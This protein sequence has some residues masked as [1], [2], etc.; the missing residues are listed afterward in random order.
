MKDNTINDKISRLFF[1][2]RNMAVKNDSPKVLQ[3]REGYVSRI[4]PKTVS[5]ARADI[6]TW[7][8][9]LRAA[10]N[11]ENP[12]RAKLQNLYSGILLDAHLTAQIELRMNHSLSVPFVLKREGQV[13]EE[14]TALLKA[15]RWKNDIDRE[16]LWANYKG[17]SLVELTTERGTLLVTSL[18]RNNIIPEKGVL[19]LSED[20]T[21]GVA[22]RDCREYGTWILEFGSREDYGL[23][24][25]AIPHV[26]FKRFAQSCWSELCEIYGIPPR[27]IKTNTQDPEMLNRAETMLRDMGSAA[28][29]IIDQEESFEFAK[30]ADTN[31]DVY[32]NLISLCNSEISLL[33][34]GAVIGQDTRNG[35][36][37]KEESSIK[38][39]DKIVQSDKRTLE[40][41]WNG[42]VLPA[43]E[44]IGIL[45]AGLVYELQQEEDIEKLW[46]MT[47]EAFPYMDI[48]PGWVK[49]KFGI[50]VTG[51][52]EMAGGANLGVD[53][54]DFFD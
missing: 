34:T 10:D 28:Y 33:I 15:A 29:F 13:D 35:N 44:R 32:N 46:V 50:Q 38:L 21:T 48:D 11:V 41:Y 42:V 18:P 45:P 31:G 16:I 14:S 23:L 4:V 27:F 26:L 51:K 37:S 53:T 40:S 54:S 52:K 22:Y 7:K 8:S 17:Y 20:D 2:R 6:G 30:G 12:R 19:L 47:R 49:D 43:L 1:P 39:L 24:N 9:A 25:K 36:R 3:R 5:R